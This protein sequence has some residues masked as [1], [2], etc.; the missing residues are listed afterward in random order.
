M[1]DLVHDLL[2]K[3]L[4][5]R[6][7]RPFGKVDGIVLEVRPGEPP[8]VRALE[9]GAATGLARLPRWLRW[10]RRLAR[11]ARVTR[12]PTSAVVKVANDITVDID[13][14][15]ARAWRGERWLAERVVARLPGGDR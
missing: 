6:E 1:L 10:T 9:V 12:I 14:P 2:D 7:G 13:A 15:R 3:Q 4:V 5:D 8:R 11:R